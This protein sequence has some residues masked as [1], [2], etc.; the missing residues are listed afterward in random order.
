MMKF[1]GRRRPRVD[2]YDEREASYMTTSTR[3]GGYEIPRESDFR[4][5]EDDTL[6]DHSIYTLFSNVNM[7][8]DDQ[9]L[10]ERSTVISTATTVKKGVP[11]PPSRRARQRPVLET[12]DIRP[13]LEAYQRNR[14]SSQS[15]TDMDSKARALQYFHPE[16]SP[17]PNNDDSTERLENIQSPP[18]VYRFEFASMDELPARKVEEGETSSVHS[19]TF[20]ETED[21]I[22][23]EVEDG[24]PLESFGFVDKEDEDD[25]HSIHENDDDNVEGSYSSSRDGSED[26]SLRVQTTDHDLLHGR[27]SPGALR[28]TAEG[29][30]QHEKKTFQ[31][32]RRQPERHADEFE[33]WRKEH[34]TRKWYRQKLKERE[35]KLLKQTTKMQMIPEETKEES[36]PARCGTSF[37]QEHSVADVSTAPLAFL[38]HLNLGR[39][40]CEKRRTFSLFRKRDKPRAAEILERERQGARETQR[41]ENHNQRKERERITRRKREYLERQRRNEITSGGALAV[42]ES[43][44]TH[45][46]TSSTMSSVS[47]STN[48]LPNCV[49][50]HNE[51][52]TH[53]AMPC[54]HFSF[55]ANCVERL[56]SA[57]IKQC[58]VCRHPNVN[59][60]SVAI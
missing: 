60:A 7:H 58:P 40:E 48:T 37:G 42:S 18:P 4:T 19:I 10:L 28:L 29:L 38:Q 51:M 56:E 5:G 24:L 20:S 35:Q 16:G 2:T 1:F 31:E 39:A 13:Q 34:E 3:T 36:K 45:Q 54:M 14:Q 52:R 25:D 43:I 26:V 23:F 55:C 30:Q 32:A 49:L 9:S 17:R 6:P 50:C 8:D 11:T 57:N 44:D 27:S 47:T 41:R 22:G 15:P 46:M 59:Y 21:E 12:N 33:A 53:I